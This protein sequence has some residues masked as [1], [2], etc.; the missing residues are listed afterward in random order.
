MSAKKIDLGGSDFSRWVLE[1]HLE[2][3]EVGQSQAALLAP[4]F[5]RAVDGM[6]ELMNRFPEVT[7]TFGDLPLRTEVAHVIA[8]AFITSHGLGYYQGK[9]GE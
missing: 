9:Q 5:D 6:M 1:S 3:G 7:D 4:T 2:D 8:P